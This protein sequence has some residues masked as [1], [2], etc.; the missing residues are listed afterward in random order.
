[1]S[2]SV[3]ATRHADHQCIC[4]IALFSIF[5]I[6]ADEIGEIRF[7]FIGDL[8]NVKTESAEEPNKIVV[9]FDL[10]RFVLLPI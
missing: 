10:C 2:R 6:P 7:I 1:M 5:E 9:V 3:T 4:S 8:N